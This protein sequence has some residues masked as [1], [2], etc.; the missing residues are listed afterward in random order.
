[1]QQQVGW[2]NV[3]GYMYITPHSGM[4]PGKQGGEE[5]IFMDNKFGLDFI[6]QAN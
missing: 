2:G 3:G 5:V 1:M 6:N 4:D